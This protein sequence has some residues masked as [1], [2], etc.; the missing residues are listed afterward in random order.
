MSGTLTSSSSKANFFKK[1]IL[2]GPRSPTGNKSHKRTFS[3]N[4]S[5]T[6]LSIGKKHSRTFSADDIAGVPVSPAKK[7]P[8]LSSEEEISLKKEAERTRQLQVRQRVH[9]AV[10]VLG[11]ESALLGDGGRSMSGVSY[12]Q[13]VKLLRRKWD[14]TGPPPT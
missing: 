14:K 1:A 5:S 7:A 8:F 6:R 4:I 13:V 12:F 3:F 2:T 11:T 10:L 9:G